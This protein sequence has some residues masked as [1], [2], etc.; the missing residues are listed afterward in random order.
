MMH[1]DYPTFF[2]QNCINFIE[3][4]DLKSAGFSD[5]C[6]LASDEIPIRDGLYQVMSNYTIPILYRMKIA[7]TILYAIPIL[8]QMITAN[9]KG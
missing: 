2:L 6:F 5:E 8:Y 9:L 7:K 1:H 3:I 4:L